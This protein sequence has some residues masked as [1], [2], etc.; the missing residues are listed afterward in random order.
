MFAAAFL[1]LYSGLGVTVGAHRLWAHRS[2]K[3][4]LPFRIFLAIGQSIA[5][6]NCIYIWSRDHRVHHKYSD[7]DADPHNS[8]RGVFFS[9]VGWLMYKKHPDLLDQAKKLKFDDLLA[10]PVVYWQQV[11]YYPIYFVFAFFLPFIVPVIFWNESVVTSFFVN[12]IFRTGYLLHGTWFINSAAHL[13]GDK[14]YDHKIPPADNKWLCWISLGEGYHNYHH[15][16]PYDYSAG[17]L[18]LLPNISRK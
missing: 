5:G 8:H 17:E 3:A 18:P 13:W 14:P 16:F 10:D 7:T 9:H 6:Q 11:F 15:T 2:Y 1:T 12:Y 4:K